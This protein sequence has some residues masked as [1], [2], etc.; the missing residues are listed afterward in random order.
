MRQFLVGIISLGLTGFGSCSTS[1]RDLCRNQLP[2]FDRSVVVSLTDLQTRFPKLKSRNLA[3]TG[4]AP[5][6]SFQARKDFQAWAEKNLKA[7]QRYA[8]IARADPTWLEVRPELN[9]IA[10]QLVHFHGYVQK[11]NV[12]NMQKTLAAMQ[13]SVE[14][15][16]EFSCNTR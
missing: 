14:K 3:Q 6:L 9:S 10:I 12:G 7:V 8:D 4:N 2:E 13:A 5:S 15:I 1:V 11:G 16:R